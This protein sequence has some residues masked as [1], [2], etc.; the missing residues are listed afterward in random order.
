[1]HYRYDRHYARRILA[2][3]SQAMY[4]AL[5]RDLIAQLDDAVETL[6]YV[7]TNVGSGDHTEQIEDETAACLKRL[8]ET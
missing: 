8:G 2:D 4:P 1:M 7:N 6:R 3:R 5:V